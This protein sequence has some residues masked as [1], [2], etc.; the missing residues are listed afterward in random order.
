[1]FCLFV[2]LF[3]CF[4]VLNCLLWFIFIGDEVSNIEIIISMPAAIGLNNSV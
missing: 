3:V 4:T 1:M 2:C